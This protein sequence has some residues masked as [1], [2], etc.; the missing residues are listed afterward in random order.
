MAT[1]KSRLGAG[2]VA[3]RNIYFIKDGLGGDFKLEGAPGAIFEVA[4]G[5][6]GIYY[7]AMT[8]KDQQN[9]SFSAYAI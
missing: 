5:F 1:D 7:T 4:Y 2:L 8:Y 9:T 6:V 3:H